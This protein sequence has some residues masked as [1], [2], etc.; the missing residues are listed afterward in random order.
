MRHLFQYFRQV[1]CKHEFE[2]SEKHVTT[3][4]YTEGTKVYL[5]CKKCGY[6]SN[7]WKFI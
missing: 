6:H 4:N 7:H 3:N 5:Y 2:I 1:F